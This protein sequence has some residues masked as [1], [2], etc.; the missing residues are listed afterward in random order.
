MLVD[1]VREV[2]MV[3]ATLKA[4]CAVCFGA[5][6]MFD[7]LDLPV[8]RCFNVQFPSGGADMVDE[9][10]RSRRRLVR[11]RVPQLKI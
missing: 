6:C 11:A 4:T 3:R 10:G 1:G 9:M 7:K 5:T 2:P 8:G